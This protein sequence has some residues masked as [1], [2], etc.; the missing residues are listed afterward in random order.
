VIAVFI[1]FA[2]GGSSAPVPRV[3]G[4]ASVRSVALAVSLTMTPICARGC[5]DPASGPGAPVAASE[6]VF[7]WMLADTRSS[8]GAAPFALMSSPRRTSD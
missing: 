5:E 6:R 3:R 8:R 2:H 7:K 1:P 4:D